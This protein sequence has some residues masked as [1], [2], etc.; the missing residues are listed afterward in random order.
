[1]MLNWFSR[2]ALVSLGLRETN[3]S[4]HIKGVLQRIEAWVMYGGVFQKLSCSTLVAKT[5]NVG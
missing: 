4:K 2:E 3:I 5:M 1:M